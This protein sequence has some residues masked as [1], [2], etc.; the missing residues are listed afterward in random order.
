MNH[1]GGFR[2]AMV[3]FTP[4]TIEMP[5]AKSFGDAF[6]F[7]REKTLHGGDAHTTS[8]YPGL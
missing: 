4:A 1:E 5:S 2:N 3:S 8:K 7:A 6:V